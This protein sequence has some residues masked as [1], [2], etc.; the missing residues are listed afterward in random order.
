MV[1]VAILQS[2]RLN[3]RFRNQGQWF[4]LQADLPWLRVKLVFST[5]FFPDGS[6]EHSLHSFHKFDLN[7]RVTVN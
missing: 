5:N 7:C 4:D 6:Y 2:V 1:K 3:M